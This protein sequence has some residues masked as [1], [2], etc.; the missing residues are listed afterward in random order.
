M[1]KSM[2]NLFT[3]NPT[4][5]PTIIE[6][7]NQCGEKCLIEIPGNPNSERHESLELLLTKC[8]RLMSFVSNAG[9]SID[10]IIGLSNKVRLSLYKADDIT[11]LYEEFDMYEYKY[12]SKSRSSM[13]L[14]H[15][16]N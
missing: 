8:K 2:L 6:A 9:E 5:R 7:V 3:P 16:E 12:K 10:D 14:I 4:N 11:P 13:N 1:F 15:L